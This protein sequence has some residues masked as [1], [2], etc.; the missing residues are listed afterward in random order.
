[1][2]I[3]NAKI[4]FIIESEHVCTNHLPTVLPVRHVVSSCPS[5]VY[6]EM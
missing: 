2:I 1:M 6:S 3:Y 5:V 4:M